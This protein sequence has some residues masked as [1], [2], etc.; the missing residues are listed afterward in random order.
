MPECAEIILSEDYADFIGRYSTS[1]EEVANQYPDQ[2]PQFVNDKYVCLY[3]ERDIIPTINVENYIYSSIPKLYGLMDTTAVAATGAIRLQNQT[4]FELT[5]KDVIVGFID[6]GI[7]YTNDLFKTTTGQTR[8][9]GIWDQT[10][11]NGNHPEGLDYGSEYTR[12]DINRA[13]SSDEPSQVVPQKDENGHGTFMAGVACGKYDEQNDFIGSAP[14]S[15]IAMVKLKPAKKYLRDYFFVPEEVPVYQENDIMLAVTYLGNLQ[16]KHNKPLVIVLGLGCGNGGRVG[17]SPLSQILDDVGNIIGNCVV[18]CSGNEGNERLH[19]SGIVVDEQVDE[20]EVRVGENNHG[21]VLELW[22]NVP[23]IFSVGFVSPFGESVER[24]PARK[25]ENETV[26]FLVEGT[27]IEVGYNIVESGSGDELI[28]MRFI[29]P[30]PGIW[31][32]RVYGSN[33]LTGRFDIW[34]NLRQ[35]TDEDTYFLRPDPER[36]ITVPAATNNAIT[37]GGYDNATNAFY[38]SSGRGFTRDNRVKPELVAPSVNVFGPGLR[39]N[40]VRKTGTSVGTALAAGCCAQLLQWGVVEGNEPFMKT[41]YI[42][43]YLIRGARRERDITYPSTE[44][45]YGEIS[46]FESFSILTRM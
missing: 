34:G 33:I 4:G 37:V 26:N 25:N 32:I 14:D 17:N 38:P 42:K 40:F 30:S 39:Q 22:G 18:V 35:F 43:S 12:E 20:V 15:L 46:V 5:G 28:F 6:T 13:L 41:N 16:L 9:L 1:R 24:I 11:N 19:Y 31:T 2:C 44:W 45:G 36:T 8:I 3:A 23:G 10:D 29:E 21:F 27:T 7:D